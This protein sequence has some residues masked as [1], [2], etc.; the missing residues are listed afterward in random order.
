MRFTQKTIFLWWKKDI[1]GTSNELG[2]L[3]VFQIN[4]DSNVVEL[5]LSTYVRKDHFSLNS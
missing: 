2:F 5:I 1:W 3:G 4:I